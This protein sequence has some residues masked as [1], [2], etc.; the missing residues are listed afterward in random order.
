M[1]S[2]RP[3]PVA[4]SKRYPSPQ[5]IHSSLTSFPSLRYRAYVDSKT[6]LYLKKKN[7]ISSSHSL[8]LDW[9][10]YLVKLV[11][12][13]FYPFS[14]FAS[15]FFTTSYPCFLSTSDGRWLT[16]TDFGPLSS[17]NSSR[18]WRPCRPLG[19]CTS[20]P[21]PL[22]LYSPTYEFMYI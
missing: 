8:W 19:D 3:R 13:L 14:P 21:V 20:S 1:L 18:Q 22:L 9:T 5:Q 16:I 15:F 12:Y 6:H 10:S 4:R 7:T 11:W 17:F 2:P